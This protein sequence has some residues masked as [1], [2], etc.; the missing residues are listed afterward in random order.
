MERSSTNGKNTAWKTI[1]SSVRTTNCKEIKLR[2]FQFK[3]LHGI[4]ETKK[5][6]FR[7]GI[8]TD[9]MNTYTVVNQIRSIIRLLIVTFRNIL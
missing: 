4:I 6:L 7:F 8:K 9:L 1:F 5:E 2:E 3:F